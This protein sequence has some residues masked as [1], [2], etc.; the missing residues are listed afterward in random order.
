MIKY[1]AL[2]ALKSVLSK[3]GV[4]EKCLYGGIIVPMELYGAEAWGI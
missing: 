4:G 3:R 1:K 2:G